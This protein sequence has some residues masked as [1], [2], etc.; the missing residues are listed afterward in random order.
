MVARLIVTAAN[1]TALLILSQSNG[2]R[3]DS[4]TAT[5]ADGPA[6]RL[7]VSTQN[8]PLQLQFEFALWTR[9]DGPTPDSAALRRDPEP[10]LSRLLRSMGLTPQRPVRRAIEQVPAKVREWLTVDY[11]ARRK[12]VRQARRFSLREAGVRSNSHRTTWAKTVVPA[13]ANGSGSG[14]GGESAGRAG[15]RR[16]DDGGA[17]HRI[18]EALT[19]Q[20]DAADLIVD[21]RTGQVPGVRSVA[22]PP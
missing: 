9:G 3:V 18:S 22:R 19:A 14:V 17:L 15:G 10:G 8:N 11:P 12:P 16:A 2:A 1:A 20:S 13:T 5:Q 7:G 21:Q 6:A 4:G